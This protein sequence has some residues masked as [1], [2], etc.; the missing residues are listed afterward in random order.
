[1]RNSHQQQGKIRDASD[2]HE[3]IKLLYKISICIL[4]QKKLLISICIFT[5]VY[6]SVFYFFILLHIILPTTVSVSGVTEP[7]NWSTAIYVFLYLSLFLLFHFGLTFCFHCLS[8]MHTYIKSIQLNKY[9]MMMM[10]MM[11]IK[12]CK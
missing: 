12:V 6:R 4:L 7:I 3:K 8:Y 11:K 1:M 10:T 2:V 9:R 5:S